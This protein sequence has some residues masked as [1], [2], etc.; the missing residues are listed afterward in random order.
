MAKE[1]KYK[2]RIKRGFL[3]GGLVGLVVPL[4]NQGIEPFFHPN[5]ISELNPISVLFLVIE[6][7]ALFIPFYREAATMTYHAIYLI[8]TWAII[9]AIIG[10]FGDTRKKVITGILMAFTVCVLV[11]WIIFYRYAEFMGNF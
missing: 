5:V 8:V 1:K 4:I 11:G 6:I 2:K 9:G 10:Y 7:P 3:I